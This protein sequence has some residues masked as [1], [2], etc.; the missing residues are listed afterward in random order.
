MSKSFII[1]SI[2]SITLFA[3]LNPFEPVSVP[4]TIVI[5]E[6]TLQP[7]EVEKKVTSVDD[8][9]RTVKIRSDEPSEVSKP[10]VI[11]KEKVVEKECVV[12]DKNVTAKPVI[13]EKIAPK[14]QIVVK[15]KPQLIEKVYKPLPFL[16]LELKKDQLK[17]DSRKKYKIIKY[18]TIPDEN[19][20]VI[21]FKGY[22]K[23][24]TKKDSFVSQ[25]FDSYVIGNHPD[26]KFFRVVIVTKKHPNEYLPYIKN[27]II[28]IYYK[29]R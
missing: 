28:T 9:D 18:F 13:V 11:I 5:P 15:P 12:E 27:N 22:V 20:I 25:E 10:K 7:I 24:Y 6:K 23:H 29:K 21:D 3:R 1:M 8:G 2:A 14:P 16:S 4:P 26:K 19:K 17:I